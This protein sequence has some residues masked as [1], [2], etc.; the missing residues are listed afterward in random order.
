MNSLLSLEELHIGFADQESD[1]P[2]TGID[3][4]NEDEGWSRCNGLK[5]NVRME[6]L[7][8]QRTITSKRNDRRN[9]AAF[10]E[11][12][13]TPTSFLAADGHVLANKRAKSS[14]GKL[15]IIFSAT[16]RRVPKNEIKNDRIFGEFSSI[17]RDNCGSRE[18]TT[19]NFERKSKVAIK[20]RAKWSVSTKRNG[21]QSSEMEFCPITDFG[22]KINA[23]F[24][25]SER[26]PVSSNA[27]MFSPKYSSNNTRLDLPNLKFDLL[28]EQPKLSW[29]KNEPPVAS[30]RNISSPCQLLKR[31]SQK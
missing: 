18:K 23:P 21:R 17:D 27:P 7:D 24:V 5:E 29:G 30:S 19:A 20:H 26:T 8:F 2:D 13:R 15:P 28:G 6:N 1:F 3:V 22:S 31:N 9:P 14:L 4:S 11:V 12:A 16:P 25:K 10:L